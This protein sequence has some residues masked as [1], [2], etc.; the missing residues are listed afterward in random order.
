MFCVYVFDA[1]VDHDAV[2]IP[3]R[4]PDSFVKA[5]AESHFA[6]AEGNE[7]AVVGVERQTQ[8]VPIEGT[9]GF[10]VRGPKDNAHD[11]CNHYCDTPC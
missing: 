3:C 9:H 4:A 7:I 11:A 2:R 1:K 8:D 5:D 6:E 10:Q